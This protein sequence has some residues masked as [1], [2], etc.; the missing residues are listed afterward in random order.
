MDDELERW[1][2]RI[3]AQLEEA[4]VERGAG[5]RGSGAGSASEGE[6]RAKR[7]HLAGPMDADGDWLDVGCANGHLLITLPTWAAG[8]GVEIVPH[9]LELLPAV[10]DLARSLNPDLADRIW[11]GSVMSWDPP[12]RFRYV[13]ALDDQAP[14][15]W[16]G[17]MVDRLLSRFVSPGGRLLVSSYTSEGAEPRPLAANLVEAG[18]RPDGIIHIDRPGKVPLQTVW[19]DK[20]LD[21][22]ERPGV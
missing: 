4:Y 2:R 12:K 22:E 21:S 10:A 3:A 18:H 15:A 1:E 13:T 20:G 14:P 7:Q 17:P 5:P 11:T 8:W 6:W 16:L 9:G 19:F